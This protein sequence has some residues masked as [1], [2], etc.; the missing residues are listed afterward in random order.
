MLELCL[1]LLFGVIVM[2][3]VSK[4]KVWFRIILILIW[5]FYLLYKFVEFTDGIKERNRKD[6]EKSS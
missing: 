6:K 5:P 4:K 1:Y 2:L 3:L